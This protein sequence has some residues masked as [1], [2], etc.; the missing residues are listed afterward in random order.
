MT[1]K[2]R[3]RFVELPARSLV[4]GAACRNGGATVMLK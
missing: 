2:S 4:G 3:A 1:A